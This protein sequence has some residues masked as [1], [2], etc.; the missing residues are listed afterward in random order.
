M[1][2]RRETLIGSSK[3]INQGD[4]CAV[5]SKKEGGHKKGSFSLSVLVPRSRDPM[6]FFRSKMSGSRAGFARNFRSSVPRPNQCL[7]K[8]TYSDTASLVI[9]YE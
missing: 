8:N 5:L 2:P 9:H 4:G 6:R 7:H 1:K 3:G